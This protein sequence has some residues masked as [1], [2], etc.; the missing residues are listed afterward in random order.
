MMVYDYKF[1][2]LAKTLFYQYCKNLHYGNLPNG[3]RFP[4]SQFYRCGVFQ[5]YQSIQRNTFRSRCG[6]GDGGHAFLPRST[7]AVARKRRLGGFLHQLG[8][9]F[10]RGDHLF[11]C[12]FPPDRFSERE[13]T[14]TLYISHEGKKLE[15]VI[16]NWD[17]FNALDENGEVM[18]D[19]VNEN[20]RD[21]S[22]DEDK[23]FVDLNGFSYRPH[24]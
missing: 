15:L 4:H 11:L 13:K 14:E 12:E 2:T 1:P 10:P 7:K 3:W 21:V 18:L 22:T 6:F 24:G 5:P 17:D 9:E 23:M 19:F 20:G 16:R 8:R